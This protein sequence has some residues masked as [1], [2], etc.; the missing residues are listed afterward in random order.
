MHPHIPEWYK[1]HLAVGGPP[2][3]PQELMQEILQRQQQVDKQQDLQNNL[4]R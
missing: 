1:T 4:K 3:D 2:R